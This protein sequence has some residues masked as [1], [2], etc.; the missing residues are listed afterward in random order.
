[1][2]R[3]RDRSDRIPRVAATRILKRKE[4][5]KNEGKK[6]TAAQGNG[7]AK[8]DAG[9][10]DDGDGRQRTEFPPEI[11]PRP[12]RPDRPDGPAGQAGARHHQTG[13][14]SCGPLVHQE[15][16]PL[17]DAL[18][19]CRAV[20]RTVSPHCIPVGQRGRHP[21]RRYLAGSAAVLWARLGARAGT[22]RGPFGMQGG[23][24][25]L[26][27]W[28]LDVFSSAPECLENVVMNVFIFFDLFLYVCVF[29]FFCR[30]SGL[31]DG[32][33]GC[34]LMRCS[35][36]IEGKDVYKLCDACERIF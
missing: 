33:G 36:W 4:K 15:P 29:F 16:P 5:N 31:V 3:R 13:A 1:M 25:T 19:R 14:E 22:V 34:R 9:G 24:P 18:K 6:E 28:D 20:A 35:D 23:T 30:G 8:E 10:A 11:V 12:D 7:A 21:C 32:K 2:K 17:G 26:Q 27:R